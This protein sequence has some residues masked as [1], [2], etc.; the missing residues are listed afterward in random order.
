MVKTRKAGAT[1][2]K[3]WEQGKRKNRGIKKGT[4][5]GGTLI[6]GERSDNKKDKTM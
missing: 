5:D 1:K 3:G 2:R 6:Y 4:G